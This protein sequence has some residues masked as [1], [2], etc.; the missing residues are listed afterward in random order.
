MF[1]EAMK[2]YTGTSSVYKPYPQAKDRAAWANLPEE[3][4]AGVLRRGEERLAEGYPML[5]MTLYLEFSRNG[6]RSHYEAP[7]LARR[8]RLNDLILAECVEHKGR[9]MDAIVDGIVCICEETSWCFPAHTAM[10]STGPEKRCCG[11]VFPFLAASIAAVA[12][13]VTPSPLR[14]EISTIRHPS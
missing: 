11:I 10:C 5:P 4:T 13:S 14:A 8:R 1:I 7:Y 9:F 12:A 2:S 6:N 3:Y